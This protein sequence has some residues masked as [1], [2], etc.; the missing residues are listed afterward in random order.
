MLKVNEPKLYIKGHVLQALPA[1][2]SS[3]WSLETRAWSALVRH[4]SYYRDHDPSTFI[5]LY[6]FIFYHKLQTNNSDQKQ[7]F[8]PMDWKIE[9]VQYWGQKHLSVELW[10]TTKV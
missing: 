6:Q 4:L 2:F 10:A 5:D 8:E 3:L 9:N 7:I 1:I